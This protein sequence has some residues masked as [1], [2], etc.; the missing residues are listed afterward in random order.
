MS[1][2]DGLA[3][4]RLVLHPT[5]FTETSEQAFAHALKIA[6][7]SKTRLYILH[8]DAGERG[9][10]DW[11]AFPSVRQTLARWGVLPEGI[12]REDVGRELGMHLAKLSTP[13]RD[14]V[15]A[16][17]RFVDEHST[18][19]IVLATHGRDGVARLTHRA[20]AEPVARAAEIPTLFVPEGARGFVD[21]ASGTLRMRNVVFPIDHRPGPDA[22]LRETRRLCQALGLTGSALHL[23]H[24]G[25]GEMPAVTVDETEFRVT[26]I[27]RSGG[28]VDEIL[29]LASECEADLIAMATAGHEGFLDALR[30]SITERVLRQAPCP[31]L[32]VGADREPEQP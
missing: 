14:P 13:D 9:D 18:D 1:E 4:I 17:L 21:G 26:R 10:V 25:D 8:A 22:A 31:V 27:A 3:P 7:A 15:R 32:A 2:N 24:V 6:L 5:D 28:V 19:L 30:G 12:A 23:L 11:S 29:A 20:I 16:I